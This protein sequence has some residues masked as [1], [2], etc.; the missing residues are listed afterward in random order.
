MQAVDCYRIVWDEPPRATNALTPP[1]GLGG[2][3]SP[4][5][6]A[7][8]ATVRE[9][10]RLWSLVVVVTIYSTPRAFAER[11]PGAG[12]KLNGSRAYTR[13][14]IGSKKSRGSDS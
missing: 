11:S 13:R 8:R 3:R 5:G 4:G 10:R 2:R 7:T 12:A 1:S 14:T 6:A 9:W